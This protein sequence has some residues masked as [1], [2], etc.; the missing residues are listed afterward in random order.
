MKKSINLLFSFLIIGCGQSSTS[1][2]SENVNSQEFINQLC[3]QA[4]LV[5]RSE[6]RKSLLNAV[7]DT[8]SRSLIYPSGK[9]LREAAKDIVN[10]YN[11]A[12]GAHASSSSIAC[13]ATEFNDTDFTLEL[14]TSNKTKNIAFRIESWIY[15]FKYQYPLSYKLRCS[16]SH[17]RNW[18]CGFTEISLPLHYEIYYRLVLSKPESKKLIKSGEYQSSN[19][20]RIVTHVERFSNLIL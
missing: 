10:P 2:L 20:S 13:N 8:A 18:I 5:T 7:E 11:L 6:M 9:R 12:D 3:E 14:S 17:E 15:Q 19:F 1:N 16:I 4:S